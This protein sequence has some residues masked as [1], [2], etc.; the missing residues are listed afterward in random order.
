[1]SNLITP[2]WTMNSV[3]DLTPKMLHNKGITG[4]IVDLDNTLIAWNELELTQRMREWIENMQQSL[5]QVFI[6]S[7]NNYTRVEKVL[8]GLKEP[9]G[10]YAQAL[11]P[12]NTG[13]QK[14]LST[15][16]VNKGC[17]AVIG[18][19]IIT[20]VIGAKRM[21]LRVILVKP[22]VPHDNIYTWVNRSLEKAL[23][24]IVNIDR[25]LDWGNQLD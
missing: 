4:I 22:L 6:V 1:M 10:F 8:S 17:V 19:Q 23:L 14:A 20:D 5:I 12:R 18:D 11:K 3:Y 16:N 24:K 13:F 7:N 15:F 2:D 25:S 21:G 9:V